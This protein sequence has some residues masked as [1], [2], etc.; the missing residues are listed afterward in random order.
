MPVILQN[1]GGVDETS[2]RDKAYNHANILL[3]SS[4][5]L[6]IAGKSN[7]QDAI[8]LYSL[9]SDYHISESKAQEVC[10]K[11]GVDLYA[12]ITVSRESANSLMLAEVKICTTSGSTM[13]MGKARTDN[14]VSNEAA[15]EM[16]IERALETFIKKTEK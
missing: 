3:L 8:S 13:Y 1:L 10:Q 15:V 5:N 4:K 16:A 6:E 14:P 7:V 9:G 2:F 12:Y 11:M